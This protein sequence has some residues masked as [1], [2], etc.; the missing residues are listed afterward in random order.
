MSCTGRI[1][2]DEGRKSAGTPSACR[3]AEGEV[4]ASTSG[5]VSG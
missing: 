4:D 1:E 3:G 2:I 5:G